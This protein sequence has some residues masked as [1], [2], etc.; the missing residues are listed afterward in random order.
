MSQSSATPPSNALSGRNDSNG[1][2][3]TL[4]SVDSAQFREKPKSSI[5]PPLVIMTSKIAKARRYEEGYAGADEEWFL[6]M[7]GQHE[8]SSLDLLNGND[9]SGRSGS[10]LVGK[11]AS[12]A[13][14]GGCSK[15][16]A[17]QDKSNKRRKV[18][19]SIAHRPKIQTPNS[20]KIRER[21]MREQEWYTKEE[22]RQ[23]KKDYMGLVERNMKRDKEKRLIGLRNFHG[24]QRGW[25]GEHQSDNPSDPEMEAGH[26]NHSFHLRVNNSRNSKIVPTVQELCA[27]SEG[28][29]LFSSFRSYVLISALRS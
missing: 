28:T 25:S 8:T 2:N 7:N 11:P 21:A 1:S 19:K 27:G 29:W 23:Q 18:S 14:P 6:G 26:E 9:H 16:K 24:S 10:E 13:Q 3:S 17:T 4:S 5:S 12:G 15:S 20:W 22:I